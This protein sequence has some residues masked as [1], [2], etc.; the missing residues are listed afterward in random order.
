[1][2][3][4]AFILGNFHGI[5]FISAVLRGEDNTVDVTYWSALIL[6]LL[7]VSVCRFITTLISSVYF[8]CGVL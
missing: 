8:V 1:M 3:Y 7:T 5:P 4:V 6:I 2:N